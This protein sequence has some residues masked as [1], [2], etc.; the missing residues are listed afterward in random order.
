MR[1]LWTAPGPTFFLRVSPDGKRMRFTVC[2][3]SGCALW[4]ANTDGS[5]AHRLLA[6]WQEHPAQNGGSWTPDGRY[7]VFG[8]FSHG[9]EY[10]SG[11][12]WLLPERR[13]WLSRRQPS[14]VQLTQGP[15][16]FYVPATFSPDGKTLFAQGHQMRAELVRYDPKTHQIVPYLSGIPAQLLAFSADGQW[17]S[18]ISVPDFS[19]WR[20]RRDG[21]ERVELMSSANSSAFISRWSPDGRKIAFEWTPNGKTFAKLALI[22]RDGGPPEQVIPDNEDDHSQNDPTWSPDGGAII[23]ARDAGMAGVERMELLRV[24]LRTKKVTPVP[25]SEGLYSPRW[26]P[27]G[28]YLAALSIG[29]HSIH[30]FDYQ[31]QVWTTWFTT[32][33]GHAGW[34]LWS[35]DSR[36]LYFQTD[37]ADHL[38]WWRIGV[39]EKTPTKIVD[40]PDERILN[41]SQTLAPDCSALYARDLSTSEIYA[42]HLSEK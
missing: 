40:L 23:F 3:Q 41:Y 11:N 19:L 2:E 10:Y 22:S 35:Q 12:L 8:V 26:S 4:E 32:Q 31:K 21:S 28:R 25:G 1:K 39:G 9:G 16:I 33:E 42:L 7:Y 5:G 38:A 37:K 34:N 30:L 27:D 24:D 13:G 20:C 14:P 29:S 18:Y 36:A 17:I 6:G 15:L